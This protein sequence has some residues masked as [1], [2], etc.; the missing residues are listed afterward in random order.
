MSRRRSRIRSTIAVAAVAL[1]LSAVATVAPA[2]PA[3]ARSAPKGI[4]V[5]LIGDSLTHYAAPTLLER[6]PKWKVDAIGG[7]KVE[8]LP[9]RIRDDLAT[10]GVPRHLVIALG[11]N[12]SPGWT[13]A[14][15]AAA[16][17]MVPRSTE[18]FF[19]TTYRDP[20]VFGQD[21]ADIQ[22]TYSSWMR[23]ISKYRDNVSFINWRGHVK[24]N[25]A[26]LRDGVHATDPEGIRYWVDLVEASI[27]HNCPCEGTALLP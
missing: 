12:E 27:A 26:L 14:D 11:T 16:V 6:R 9:R 17:D 4:P 7:R 24:R 19:I 10:Y 22:E 18:V 20:A 13:R 3:H 1:G 23:S 8:T 25:P 5:L 15:Y 2:T 21:R